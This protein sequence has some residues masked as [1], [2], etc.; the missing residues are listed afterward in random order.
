MIHQRLH[1]LTNQHPHTILKSNWISIMSSPR[2]S[3]Y[4]HFSR[5]SS[6][7]ILK[8]EYSDDDYEDV[9]D[10]DKHDENSLRSSIFH[11]GLSRSYVSKWQPKDAFREFYQN[12]YVICTCMQRGYFAYSIQEG[13]HHNHL[14]PRISVISTYDQRNS[15]TDLDNLTTSISVEEWRQQQQ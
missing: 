10:D 11:F 4:G 15:H 14:H 13:C 12:W 6:P 2:P 9:P 1:P 7:S 8:N 3:A 5:T